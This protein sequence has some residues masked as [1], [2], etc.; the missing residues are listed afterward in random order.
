MSDLIFF[1]QATPADIPAMSAIRLAVRE[2]VLSDPGR[3]TQQMY[4]DYLE[5]VGR[6][7]VAQTDGEIA[8]FC[9]ADKR[10]ASIWALFIAEEYEGRGMAKRLLRLAVDWLFDQGHATVHLTTTPG[11]RADGF[12]ATQGWARTEISEREVGFRIFKD[13]FQG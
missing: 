6:G 2:N 12:Y 7:W 3:V 5:L 8:G 13:S 4:V 10:T 11:T 1:R 9:Y